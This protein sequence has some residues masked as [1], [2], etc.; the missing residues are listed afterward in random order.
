MTHVI[1]KLRLNIGKNPHFRRNFYHSQ[2]AIFW[3]CGFGLRIRSIGPKCMRPTPEI[4]FWKM[5]PMEQKFWEKV[6]GGAHIF[7]KSGFSGRNTILCSTGRH[8]DNFQNFTFFYSFPIPNQQGLLKYHTQPA[9]QTPK[10]QISWYL[11]GFYQSTRI[12]SHIV[13]LELSSVNSFF[14]LSSGFVTSCVRGLGKP[15]YLG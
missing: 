7:P 9:L 12:P 5:F 10:V 1:S 6:S 14:L 8:D 3:K 2:T 11:C 4:H 13:H 15:C